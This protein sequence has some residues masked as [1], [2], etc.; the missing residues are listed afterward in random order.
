MIMSDMTVFTKIG[1]NLS[2]FSWMAMNMTSLYI[3]NSNRKLVPK[4][5]SAVRWPASGDYIY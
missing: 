1:Y 2:Q 3:P 5:M 4:Y